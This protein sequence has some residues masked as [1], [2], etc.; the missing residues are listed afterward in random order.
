MPDFK[1]HPKQDFRGGGAL[2]F[3]GSPRTFYHSGA[4]LRERPPLRFDCFPLYLR[5]D[6]VF[7]QIVEFSGFHLERGI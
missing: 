6:P 2:R 4:S 3:S 7:L 1:E 5:H